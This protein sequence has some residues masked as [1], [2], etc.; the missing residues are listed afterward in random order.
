MERLT[1]SKIDIEK[2][3][4]KA[5]SRLTKEYIEKVKLNNK[6]AEFEDFIEENGFESLEDLQRYIEL[7]IRT[8]GIVAKKRQ[9]IR[10]FKDRWQKLKEF[11][12]IN[13]TYNENI[14]KEARLETDYYIKGCARYDA[15]NKVLNEMKKLEKEI[16]SLKIF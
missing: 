8:S 15:I 10:T 1:K 3:S 11:L 5:R 16:K 9:E 6:L 7:S 13:L 2:F 12:E 4:E 14:I